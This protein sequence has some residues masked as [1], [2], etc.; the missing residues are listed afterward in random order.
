MT[1]WK[2][3]GTDDTT[4]QEISF[5]D[6]IASSIHDMKNSLNIQVSSL[7]KLALRCEQLGDQPSFEGLGQ[8]I[9][10]ANRLNSN[11]IQLLSLYK[12][13]KS[14]YPTDIV[15]HALID[16]IDEALQRYQSV[17]DF[18]GITIS[19]DCDPSCYWYFDR[20]LV[21]GVLI[22]ALNNA[23]RYTSD[24]IHIAAKIEA[25]FLELRVEDNGAGYPESMLQNDCMEA[26]K[27]INFSNGSTGL[28]FYFSNRVVKMHKNSSR[29][30]SL[31]IE[32]GG[33]YGGG[34]FVMKLP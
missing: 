9:Y 33:L 8:I 22:N 26:H 19:V 10:Q 15:E 5:T 17:L 12:L 7:E 6:F 21:I 28:G 1:S 3:M 29:E 25:G 31:I 20:D 34:C 32:N 24:K 27:G 14:I 18:K 2:K 16:V 4:E 11:L 23:Y 30:G 13:G